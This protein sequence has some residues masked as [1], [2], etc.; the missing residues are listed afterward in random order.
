[1]SKTS[2]NV[3]ELFQELE[4]IVEWFSSEKVE[5]EESLS[6]YEQ[7]LEI[8]QQLESKL[9]KIDDKLKVI[10]KKFKL[11]VNFAKFRF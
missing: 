4:E 11:V 6:K 9:G 1:M 8:I 5:L 10:H 2:K 7:G 3:S